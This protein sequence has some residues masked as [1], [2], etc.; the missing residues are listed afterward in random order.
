MLQRHRHLMLNDTKG[1]KIV[2]VTK[3]G[4]LRKGRIAPQYSFKQPFLTED[5]RETFSYPTEGKPDLNSNYYSLPKL[6]YFIAGEIENYALK[7]SGKLKEK[8][9]TNL[10]VDQ[11]FFL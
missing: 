9:P 3:S 8:N 5:T 1:N 7:L 2:N 6:T 10:K 11:Y 4:D